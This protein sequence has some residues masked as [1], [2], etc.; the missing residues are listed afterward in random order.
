MKKIVLSLAAMV[1]SGMIFAQQD[2]ISSIFEKYAGKEGFVTVTLTGDMLKMA[3]QMQEYKKDTTLISRL[4]ELKILVHEKSAAET[5]VNFYTEVYKLV[6]KS[7]F[8]ELM[9]VKEEDTDITMLARESDGVISEFILL[10][11]GDEDNVLIHAKGNIL[12]R[13]LAEMAG[14]Y[15]LKGF[16]QFKMPKR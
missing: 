11:G 16:D 6:D 1:F 4:A 8:K 7:V 5:D 9:T 15:N 12:L 10:V 13:E 14:N 3:A 2:P